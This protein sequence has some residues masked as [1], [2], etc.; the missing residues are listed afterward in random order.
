MSLVQNGFPTPIPC[1]AAPLG[2]PPGRAG[3]RGRQRA[4]GW[5]SLRAESRESSGANMAADYHSDAGCPDC[6]HVRS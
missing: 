2:V 3:G 5:P 6:A 1:C 4:E